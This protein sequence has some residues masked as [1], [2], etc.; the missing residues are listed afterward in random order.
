MIA[1]TAVAQA[2]SEGAKLWNT[3]LKS[4][5]RRRFK[6]A[7]EAAE[8]YIF[9]NQKSGEFKDIDDSR[10]K[11]LLSHYSRKFFSYN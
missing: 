10:K 8:K 3:W 4:F 6:A 11:K 2:I 7:I 5:E 1:I 9:V